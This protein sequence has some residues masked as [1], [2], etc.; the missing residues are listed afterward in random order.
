MIRS[1][2]V[3]VKVAPRKDQKASRIAELEAALLRERRISQALRDVGLALGS[4][5]DLDRL[6]ELILSRLTELL[7]ADR[8]TLFL[9][10]EARSELVSCLV[11][12]GSLR[13]LR[14]PLGQGVAG[15]VARTG[16][17]LRIADAYL[18]PRFDRAYDDLTGYRTRSILALPMKNH[19]GKILGVVQALNK[20]DG[21]FDECDEELLGALATQAA[22][23]I[24]HSR[25]LVSQVEKNKQLVDTTE[26]LERRVRDLDLL[27]ELESAMARA[28]SQDELLCSV[29]S[30]AMRVCEAEAGAMLLADDASGDLL[31]HYY[32]PAPKDAIRVVRM[33]SGEGFTGWAMQH[34][35][36]LV[37]DDAKND[38]RIS[39]RAVKELGLDVLSSAL[40]APLEGEGG[41]PLGAMGIYN[42][43]N[44]RRFSQEDLELVRLI[45]AN[46]STAIQLF[47][48]RL[49]RE[50]EE[51]LS[52]IGRL[53]S[54][55]I[56]DFKT[57]MT[58]ISGYVQ[59]MASARS[60]EQ[61]KEY[62]ELV[63]KQF[64]LIAAMQRE[65]LEFARGERNV[66]IR[67]VYLSQFFRDVMEQLE[68]EVSGK[69][70][71]LE[72]ELADR[73][74]ARFDEGKVLRAIH[75]LARNAVEAMG[76]KGGA[77]TV[78]VSRAK[79]EGSA[80]MPELVI[81]VRDTG[82]GI[83][84]AIEGQI[85]ESF[86]TGGKKGGTGLGLAIVKKI[87]VEHGGSVS[88][89]SSERG[90]SFKLHIPQREAKS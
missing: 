56:H 19:V 80:D 24:D 63:L 88:V 38:G 14:V 18:D 52:T 81:E 5:L 3:T 11:T 45:A 48:S 10:D 27:F 61:R 49:A 57:P 9:L 77:L 90:T 70:V 76:E 62:V 74:I 20:R 71:R 28:S 65:V 86:V 51:R 82:P 6:L 60:D 2:A 33:K 22:V 12:G 67:K 35:E 50:R 58:V 83:P 66:L 89:E 41:R 7:E 29:L 64:D 73:G 23:S 69:P 59:M 13:T 40:A 42:K 8:A 30:E 16:E 31:L 44:G 46:A 39:E 34:G 53:L 47:R 15:F 75:N 4:T 43:R 1:R 26:Q 36:T 32:E 72:L 78:A 55:V 84:K 68:R 54:S 37:V 79:V 17:T 25:L 87:A 85:F 21:D